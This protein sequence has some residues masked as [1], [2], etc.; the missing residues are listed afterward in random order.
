MAGREMTLVPALC[1]CRAYRRRA[2]ACCEPLCSDSSGPTYNNILISQNSLLL[3]KMLH[4]ALL[5][6]NKRRLLLGMTKM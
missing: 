5:Y 4:T 3:E 1:S 2:A 6:I